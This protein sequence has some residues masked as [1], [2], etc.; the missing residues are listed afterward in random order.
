[1]PDP[2]QSSRSKLTWAKDN[3]LPDLNRRLCEFH[4]LEPY[5]KVVETDPK[6]PG[7]EV[8]KI[9]LVEPFPEAFGNLTFDIVSNLRSVLDNAGYRERS[10][11]PWPAS[12]TLPDC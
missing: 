9:K 12:A 6:I 1:V 5:T 8:H 2:F 3:L 10:A 11:S 7:W 4:D